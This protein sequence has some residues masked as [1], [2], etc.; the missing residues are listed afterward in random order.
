MYAQRIHDIGA[1]D[2]DRVC[3]QFE[4]RRDFFIRFALADQLQDFNF[5]RRQSRVALTLQRFLFRKLVVEHSFPVHDATNRCAQFQIHRV[6]Q[7]VTARAGIER[8]PHPGFFSVHAEHQYE[9]IGS[10]LQDFSGGL[11]PIHSR[12]G[13]IHYDNTRGQRPCQ[14]DR[15]FT[16]AGLADHM[17]IRL[18]LEH[19]PKS[20][21]H[22]A[23][24][25]HQQYGDLFFRHEAPILFEEQPFA[26]TLLQ[27]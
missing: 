19:A 24:I 20:A 3:A 25:I 4:L 2:G 16:V 10:R 18:V 14:L 6:L 12:Q 27:Q 21:A 22:Q 7:H 26:P 13:A 1:M 9:R 8:L 15:F 17:E 23:V 11:K 5:A